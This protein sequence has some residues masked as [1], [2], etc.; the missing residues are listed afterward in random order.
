MA[1]EELRSNLAA[2][3]AEGEVRTRA[4]VDE[5][6]SELASRF[7]MEPDKVRLLWL[8]VARQARPVGAPVEVY[9]S[10]AKQHHGIDVEVIDLGQFSAKHSNSCMFLT[11][12]AAI[13]DRVSLGLHELPPG[14]LR[15]DIAAAAPC[16]N[17]G[18][19]IDEL[20]EQH[21]RTRSGTLGRMADALREAACN[22]L[23]EDA[24]FFQPF[25]SP[26]RG[27]AGRDDA[28]A[29][30]NQYAEWVEK[31][32]GDEEGDELVIMAV[33]RL[34]GLAVQPVQQSGYRVPMMDPTGASA[35]H[36]ASFW[37]NDDR[38]WVWLRT[39]GD[40]PEPL[41]Q[42]ARL[43]AASAPAEAAPPPPLAWEPP[44][45]PEAATPTAASALPA[46]VAAPPTSSAKSEF[47]IGL[48]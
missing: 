21:R 27:R 17:A 44:P 43:S 8:T 13:A 28:I 30:A 10:L 25:F 19:P 46:A 42:P 29:M 31:L 5:V 23:V 37:G 3:Q 12:S 26:V 15:D 35:C 48:F 47:S 39:A 34:L 7:L 38:H 33:S 40:A 24:A 45:A 6:I 22:L 36:G 2:W 4:Q 14:P 1:L 18:S 11:C 20:I 41:A 16:S 9:V 32:R